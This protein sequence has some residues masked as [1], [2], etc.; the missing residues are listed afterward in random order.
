MNRPVAA[1]AAA[2]AAV[3]APHDSPIQAR[4]EKS[5]DS[6]S[7]ARD[8]A[9]GFRADA[10]AGLVVLPWSAVLGAGVSGLATARDGGVPAD[11]GGGG[12]DPPAE[13]AAGLDAFGPVGVAS[14]S[15]AGCF[16][17]SGM[18]VCRPLLVVP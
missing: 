17:S 7:A 15:P 3:N 14:V 11:V 9:T 6:S 18:P 4:L 10:A 13:G 8:E 12:G 5:G 2:E 1:N 16:V